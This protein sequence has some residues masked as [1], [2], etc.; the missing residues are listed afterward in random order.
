[1]KNKNQINRKMALAS[2]LLAASGWC[3]GGSIRD[4]DTPL[5]LSYQ[6]RA[7]DTNSEYLVATT[8]EDEVAFKDYAVLA[9]ENFQIK[10]KLSKLNKILRNYEVEF[11]RS[12]PSGKIGFCIVNYFAGEERINIKSIEATSSG[13]SRSALVLNES[14]ILEKISLPQNWKECCVSTSLDHRGFALPA[15]CRRPR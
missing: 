6:Y 8:F 2:I 7:L 1:M 5:V 13:H 9:A 15:Q 12:L 10:S 4:H 11:I 14:N 3:A